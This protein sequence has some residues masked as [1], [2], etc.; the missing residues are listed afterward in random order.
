MGHLRTAIICELVE[1]ALQ[2]QQ[3]RSDHL[4]QDL[5]R[6]GQR[7]A[8]TVMMFAVASP[9]LQALGPGASD[10]GYARLPNR[11]STH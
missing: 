7:P 6:A 5:A 9:K 10:V 1:Q 11:V 2:I 4:E 3:L 8:N